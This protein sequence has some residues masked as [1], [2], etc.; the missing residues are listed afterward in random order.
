MEWDKIT[1]EDL[2]ANC[3]ALV[4]AISEEALTGFDAKIADL[5]T[6]IQEAATAEQETEDAVTETEEAE[7]VVA[8]S[9]TTE[10]ETRLAAVEMRERQQDAREVLQVSLAEASITDAGKALVER[11]FVDNAPD[12]KAKFT[13]TVTAE[14]KAIA[15]HEQAIAESVRLPGTPGVLK[16]TGETVEVDVVA[17]IAQASGVPKQDK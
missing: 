11:R 9:N 10:F 16:E 17:G 14:I 3:A 7:L 12:D 2:K 1:L 15:D 13:E 5:E 8:E 4:N 6:Q